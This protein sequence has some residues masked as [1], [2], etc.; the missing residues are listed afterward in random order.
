MVAD[1]DGGTEIEQKMNKTIKETYLD[2]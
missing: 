1:N 2:G